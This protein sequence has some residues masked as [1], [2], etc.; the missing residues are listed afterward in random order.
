M[1]SLVC[2]LIRDPQVSL[3]PAPGFTYFKIMFFVGIGAKLNQSWRKYISSVKDEKYEGY[4][5]LTTDFQ[6]T[7]CKN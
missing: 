7:Y 2:I 5:S 3:S 1:D 6:I 4:V